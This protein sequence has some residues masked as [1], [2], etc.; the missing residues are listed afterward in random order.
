MNWKEFERKHL[1]HNQGTITTLA[2]RDWG[3]PCE[4]SVRITTV[5]TKIQ[6]EQLQNTS[7]ESYHY[8]NLLGFRVF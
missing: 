1:R 8:A 7:L 4:T 3:K 2:W 6:T 5:P